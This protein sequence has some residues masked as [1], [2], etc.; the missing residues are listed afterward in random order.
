MTA[1]G[2]SCKPHVTTIENCLEKTAIPPP[3]PI[4]TFRRLEPLFPVSKK[5]R[6]QEKTK[7]SVET[8]KERN[9]QRLTLLLV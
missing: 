8:Q 3:D 1:S 2:S 6:K 4:L 9:T 5:N 7:I